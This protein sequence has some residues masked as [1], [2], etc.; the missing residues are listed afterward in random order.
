M[1][2]ELGQLGAPFEDPQSPIRYKLDYLGHSFV[3][4]MNNTDIEWE[5]YNIIQRVIF[6]CALNPKYFLPAFFFVISIIMFVN[7]RE[8]N[9][10]LEQQ[11]KVSSLNFF[12]V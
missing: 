4:S 3:F 12:E 1:I 5:K 11:R 2:L 8:A 9:R 7:C 10:L 6:W